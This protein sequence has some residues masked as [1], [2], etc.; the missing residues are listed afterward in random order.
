MG[1]WRRIRAGRVVA[2]LLALAACGQLLELPER[3][4]LPNVAACTPD[5]GCTCEPGFEDC[6]GI[7]DNGCEVDLLAGARC[8]C[9]PKLW[10]LPP[11]APSGPVE[12][13]PIV[14]A[15]RSVAVVDKGGPVGFDL[16]R[17]CTCDP[18]P[19]SKCPCGEYCDC[20]QV[21]N[22]ESCRPLYPKLPPVCD[23]PGGVD[24]AGAKL[25]EQAT[26]LLGIDVQS[27][28]DGLTEGIWTALISVRGYDGQPND[29]QVEAAFY[30]SPPFD[31]DP[32]NPKQ[33]KP[34]W[35]GTDRWPI[36]SD[37]LVGGGSLE[38]EVDGR[39]TCGDTLKLDL[40]KP[41]YVDPN[42]YVVD[43][44]LVAQWPDRVAFALNGDNA[45]VAFELYQTVITGRLVRDGAPSP[46]ETEKTRRLREATL[47]G[48]WTQEA[49][50]ATIGPLR[51]GKNATPV[52]KDVALA[53]L[54]SSFFC[55]LLDVRVTAGGPTSPC[56]ALSFGFRFEAEQAAFG[57][58][59]RPSKITT[60]CTEE[61]LK[62]LGC[63]GAP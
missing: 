48:R 28:N 24:N 30:G 12:G 34:R 63:A 33:S 35:D 3:Q 61:D 52:C 21:T 13:E 59:R 49:L 57:T 26:A 7:L 16:D 37:A 39:Q 8:L 44:V 29:G 17:F 14:L 11:L 43:G 2:P 56:D 60:A 62:S 36:R 58:V 55:P 47:G 1:G 54:A 51:A 50:R 23:G 15:I 9:E 18:D 42:A 20:A 5:G 31:G 10:P 22:A 32:C 27:W 25:I 40:A 45:N 53:V 46:G 38:A 6:D 41:A 4:T 19:M